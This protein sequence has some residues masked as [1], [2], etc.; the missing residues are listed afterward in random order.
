MISLAK[1][2]NTANNSSTRTVKHVSGSENG[3]MGG[4]S[5]LPLQESAVN[6]LKLALELQLEELKTCEEKYRHTTSLR[7]DRRNMLRARRE[8]RRRGTTSSSVYRGKQEIAE[9]TARDKLENVRQL[10]QYPY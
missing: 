3:N 4:T 5:I 8:E 9:T 6:S 2:A 1:A 10:H 7:N